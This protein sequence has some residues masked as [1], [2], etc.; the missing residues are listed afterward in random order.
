MTPVLTTSH[1]G[2]RGK[3]ANLGIAK[4]MCDNSR[5]SNYKAY[6]SAE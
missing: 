2:K 4:T 5:L 6:A 1:D 3:I